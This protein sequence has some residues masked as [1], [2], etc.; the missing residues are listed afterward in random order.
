MAKFYISINQFAEFSEATE[1]SKKRIIKQQKTP[2]KF[3]IPWYQKAKGAIKKFFT[4]TKDYSPIENA[5]KELE[6]KV[7][8]NDRQ[9]NDRAA[10]IQALEVMKKIKL[11]RILSS[12][13]Y[14]VVTTDDKEIH[15]NDVDVK[16]APEIIIKASYKN[17][18]IYGAVK[19]H[20]C[21]GKPF[22]HVQCSYV[23]A[24]LYQHLTKKVIKKG[25]RVLP[26]LCLCLDVFAER[27]VPAPENIAAVSSTIRIICGDIKRL[28][29]A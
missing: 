2:N 6:A 10:S 23:A 8:I 16:I 27:L 22:N 20:I 29:S 3:L 21:K 17:E 25:E 15:I 19:I 4:D 18:I 7:P 24:L 13:S 11:P 14:E 28:W 9:R 1:S 12:L 26:E 5:I